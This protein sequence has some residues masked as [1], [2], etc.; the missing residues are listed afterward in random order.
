MSFLTRKLF[1]YVV[2]VF[3]VSVTTTLLFMAGTSRHERNEVAMASRRNV[4]ERVHAVRNPE[5]IRRVSSPKDNGISNASVRPAKAIPDD[6]CRQLGAT[7]PPGAPKEK[8]SQA[9]SDKNQVMDELLNQDQI[10]ADYGTQMVA[11]FRDPGQ[12]LLTR[13]FAVQHIG[14]YAQALRRR[15]IYDPASVEARTLRMALDE[16]A[17][18]TKTII[19]AAAFRALAD[20]A[21]FDPHVDGRRLDAR[22]AACAGDDSAA[23]AAR[24]M[25]VHLCGE[26]RVV[27]AR[28]T[29]ASLADAQ[30][31]PTPLRLAAR[32]SLRMLSSARDGNI[33]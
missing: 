28:A 9:A 7:L 4:A 6:A 17:S 31:T 3:V 33:L 15:G 2:A 30:S 8:L 16:A 26:R 27:S 5:R 1:I 24:V 23:P 19:A 21:A 11:L 32:A 13:D 14:L 29:L 25:A 10:P 12:D 18:D 20:V 22:I